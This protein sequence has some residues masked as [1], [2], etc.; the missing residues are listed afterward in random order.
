MS[1]KNNRQNLLV[2]SIFGGLGDP[3]IIESKRSEAVGFSEKNKYIKLVA[4]VRAVILILVITIRGYNA[5]IQ[6]NISGPC[7]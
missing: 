2:G 6:E 4:S 7:K 3:V 1:G 5:P